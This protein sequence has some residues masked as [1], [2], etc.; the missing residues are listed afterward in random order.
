MMAKVLP[1]YTAE[2]G[3]PG[4][5]A[6][7]EQWR[8]DMRTDL[9]AIKAWE[10]GLWQSIDARPL[11]AKIQCPTLVLVGALDLIC[12]PTQRLIPA[13]WAQAAD[14]YWPDGQSGKLDASGHCTYDR[15]VL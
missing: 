12:G 10:S 5:Q 3:R 8:R 2:P 9:A 13:T 1:L 7:I 11:L 15:R 14:A 6:M 4:V